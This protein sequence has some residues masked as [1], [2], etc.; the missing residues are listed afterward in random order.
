MGACSSSVSGILEN[1]NSHL[2]PGFTP[3]RPCSSTS[4][5]GCSPESAG[6]FARGDSSQKGNRLP[7]DP[8]SS[9]SAPGDSPLPSE[10][11]QSLPLLI[12]PQSSPLT[13]PAMTSSCEE[14]YSTSTTKV[15]GE[16]VT[17]AGTTNLLTVQLRTWLRALF[18]WWH[19][20]TAPA[21]HNCV[22]MTVLESLGGT[23]ILNNGQWFSDTWSKRFGK[24]KAMW[25]ALETRLP[26]EIVERRLTAVSP[27]WGSN[28]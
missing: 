13:T 6:T 25:K 10:L 14:R 2:A 3:Q 22:L 18:T 4:E 26:T 8:R 16:P 20:W 17:W 28:S 21:M 9:L 12:S 19:L 15:Q 24:G 7:C 11:H 5:C 27:T 1:H 23:D